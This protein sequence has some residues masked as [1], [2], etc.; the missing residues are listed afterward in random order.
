MWTHS[1]HQQLLTTKECQNTHQTSWLPRTP[2]M[3][4]N[5][6]GQIWWEQ[7]LEDAIPMKFQ[8]KFQ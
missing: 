5:M 7:S 6:L 4:T 2:N 8:M 3:H 1:I